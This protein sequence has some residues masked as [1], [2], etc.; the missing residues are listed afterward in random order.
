MNQSENQSE[1]DWAALFLEVKR[2]NRLIAA[3][4]CPLCGGEWG[5]GPQGHADDCPNAHPPARPTGPGRAWRR[6][7]GRERHGSRRRRMTPAEKERCG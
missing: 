1:T 6:G 5:N 3:G 7:R 4:I 2:Q